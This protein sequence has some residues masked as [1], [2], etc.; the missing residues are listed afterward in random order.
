M[1]GSPHYMSP[2]QMASSRDVDA[3]ADVWSMGVV[4]YQLLTGR[5]PF[6]GKALA[7]I[8]SAVL[9]GRPAPPSTLV[10]GL[11]PEIDAAVLA[12][13]ERDR[14]RR[15]AGVAQL[16]AAVAPFAPRGA[17]ASLG[18]LLG[19]A[20]PLT[21]SAR[22]RIPTPLLIAGAFLLGGVLAFLLLR[23]R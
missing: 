19:P 12:C 20:T 21:V 10:A 2:E 9:Q 17:P 13:L 7:E 3:R 6:E 11:P 16:A 1:L 22:M 4:A 23:L 5:V 15:C 18:R 14:E 8:V